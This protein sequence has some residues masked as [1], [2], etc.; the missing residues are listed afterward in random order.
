MKTFYFYQCASRAIFQNGLFTLFL[1]GR[2]VSL[3]QAF[4]LQIV[5]LTTRFGSEIPVSVIGVRFG[6]RACVLVGLFL[7]TLVAALSP[8]SEGFAAFLS[9]FVIQ[10]IAL[11]FVGCERELLFDILRADRR[12]QDYPLMESRMRAIGSLALAV[13]TV[14][15]GW[16]S[17]F[18]WTTVYL[19]TSMG[20][21]LGGLA[22]FTM[23]DVP[24]VYSDVSSRSASLHQG[25]VIPLS[26]CVQAFLL[27]YGWSAD[28]IAL[29]LAIPY[30]AYG[31]AHFYR[32]E[33]S[34]TAHS[35]VE[36]V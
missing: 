9:L 3:L 18:S 16:L 1:F 25:L 32:L 22:I 7:C 12:S 4:T 21:A 26:L 15:G 20:L 8:I 10:G 11:A 36:A 27:G 24:P 23:R 5:L 31:V 34:D 13:A 29:L 2:D 6:R 30:F 35:F 17:S 14:T 28:A 33:F 19:G